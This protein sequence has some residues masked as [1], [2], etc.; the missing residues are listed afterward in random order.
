MLTSLIPLYMMLTA[1]R[2]KAQLASKD[3]KL[4]KTFYQSLN[5]DN[6]GLSHLVIGLGECF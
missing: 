5:K 2:H 6:L 1:T 3:L 4:K